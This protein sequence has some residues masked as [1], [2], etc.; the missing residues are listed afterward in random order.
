MSRAARLRAFDGWFYG[1]LTATAV[2]DAM[3]FVVLALLA[4]EGSP[5]KI[6]DATFVTATFVLPLTFFATCILTAVPAAI[7]IWFG[8]RLR[9]RAM[10]FYVGSG[11]VV[12]A[13]FCALLFK[14]IGWLGAAF[15][16][17]G[18]P[19]GLVY[20]RLAGRYVGED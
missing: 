1:C 19:A 12:G 9:T 17:A 2:L 18:G 6:V 5:K 16:L 15:V 3:I 11:V 14:D 7:L 10:A 4:P 20:W 13:L 8:E